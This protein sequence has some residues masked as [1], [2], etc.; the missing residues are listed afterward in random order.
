VL[1]TR[2]NSVQAFLNAGVLAFLVAGLLACV[3][4]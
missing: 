1:A 4:S 2:R 3:L